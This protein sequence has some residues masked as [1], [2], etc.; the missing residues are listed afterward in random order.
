MGDETSLWSQPSGF[1]IEH[2]EISSPFIDSSD[3]SLD[4]MVLH[5]IKR[6]ATSPPLAFFENGSD[7]KISDYR[8]YLLS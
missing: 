1:Y 2:K 7:V 5:L 6:E 3:D 4:S 8:R